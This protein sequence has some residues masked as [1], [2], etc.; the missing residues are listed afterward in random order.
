MFRRARWA[1]LPAL[2]A[3]WLAATDPGT[4][5]EGQPVTD[6]AGLF[7]PAAVQKANDEIRGIERAEHKDLVVETFKGVPEDK[8]RA[9]AGMTRRARQDF[10][11]QWAETRARERH[12][13]GVY[14]LLCRSPRGA[15]AV[16]GPDTDEHVFPARDRERLADDLRPRL[17]P[18]NYDRDLLRA[19]D[20]FH[21]TLHHNL[22]AGTTED[23]GRI[24]PGT[25]G[26]I[27]GLLGLWGALG[28][29][30]RAVARLERGRPAEAADPVPART[31]EGLVPEPV[32]QAGGLTDLER[33]ALDD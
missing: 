20:W 4:A 2:A 27:A 33:R 25:L 8:A 26:T 31:G 13:D 17:W 18:R 12:V 5:A 1:W 24:W 29:A 28:L 3:G 15:V 19:V 21:A 30:R 10:L 14:V 9:F 22:V 16:L 23:P 6:N 11:Y 32:P 7:S